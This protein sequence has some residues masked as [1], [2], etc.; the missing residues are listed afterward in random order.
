MQN[1][2]NTERNR[3]LLEVVEN[4]LEKC[5][6]ENIEVRVLGGAGVFLKCRAYQDL[7]NKD[8][9]PFSD[10]DLI[11]GQKYIDRLETVFDEM[12]FEQ[13]RNFKILFGYQRR[14]FYTPMNI[15][16][17]VYLDDLHLCREIEISDRLLLDYPTL[18]PTDLLLS[19]I[20]RFDLKDK[21]IIDIL[22]LLASFDLSG[23]N[24][25][26]V[27]LDYISRLC[28][29]EWGWWKTFKVNTAKLYHNNKKGFSPRERDQINGKLKQLENAI[30]SG[31]KSL[32]WKFRAI[33]GEKI[34][35][36][37]HVDEGL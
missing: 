34:R 24:N 32:K 20:Q 36:Y 27:D 1:I 19:K 30:D 29:N 28:S 9:K 3:I 7:M 8:R 15:T 31:K 12:K 11:T 23:K 22:V 26:N 25:N 37:K 5:K 13:N 21:D 6:Q 10:I 4:I 18:S 35:W 14:I 16:V 33:L 2:S 17:E